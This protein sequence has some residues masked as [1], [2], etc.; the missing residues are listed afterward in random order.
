MCSDNCERQIWTDTHVHWTLPLELIDL[1]T[2][3]HFAEDFLPG[4]RYVPEVKMS[5]QIILQ[6]YF[7]NFGHLKD[8][9][10]CL[11]SPQ[12][13]CYLH[14]QTCNTCDKLMVHELFNGVRSSCFS[15]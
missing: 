15:F 8:F 6:Q 1:Q 10:K 13:T 9:E 5:L 3:S 4:Y 11:R 2:H 7:R 14:D 12:T